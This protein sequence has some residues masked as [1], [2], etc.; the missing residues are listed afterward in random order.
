MAHKLDPTEKY[1]RSFDRK[2]KTLAKQIGPIG[3]DCFKKFGIPTA[4]KLFSDHFAECIRNMKREL[5]QMEQEEKIQA[6]LDATHR[7]YHWL[8]EHRDEITPEEFRV[9][10]RDLGNMIHDLPAR[11]TGFRTQASIDS[12]QKTKEHFHPRQWAGNVIM[13]YIYHHEGI[14]KET[15]RAFFDVFR[16]VH[17]TTETENQLLRPSQ[18]AATYD[19]WEEPYSKVCSPLVQIVDNGPILKVEDIWDVKLVAI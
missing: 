10:A 8:W 2:L 3:Q 13:S 4:T 6:K 12:N 14:S 7:K 1:Q 16:Q 18:E 9:H 15:L 17:Q 5:R 11:W 19:G